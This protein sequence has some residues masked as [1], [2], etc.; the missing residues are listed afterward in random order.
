MS[1]ERAARTIGILAHVDA[2]KTT[3]SERILYLTGAVRALGRVDRGDTVLDSDAIERARGITVFSDQADFVHNGRRYTLIDTPGH[4][5]FAQETERALMALDAA[6][7]MVDAS[8]GVRPHAALLYSLA[9]AR[10]VPVMLFLNKCD[11]ESADPERTLHQARERLNAEPIL[12]PVDPER[13]AELD[14]AFL[15]SYLSGEW[16]EDDLDRALS[17]AFASGACIPALC[18]SALRGGGVGEL[19]N[20]LDKLIPERNID[21]NAPL[22][23]VVYKIRRDSR[24]QRMAFIKLEAG[25]LKP[26]DVFAGGE[27]TEK[28]GEIRRAFGNRY[29]SIGEARA[30]DAVAVTGLSTVSP[31]DR[32]EMSGG[33]R[34]W[35]HAQE[36]TIRAAL[37]AKVEALDGTSP[38]LLNEKLRL[39]EDEDPLLNVR[40]DAATKE[41]L[42][43]VMGPIQLEV[44][45]QMLLE[46]FGIRAH[47]LPSEVVYMETIASPVLGCG[48][49]EPLRHY[50]E[51]ILRLEP[52][53]RGSGITFESRCHVDTLAIQYQ[54]LIRSHVF[55]R[56]HRGK[57]IGAELADVHVVLLNGRAHEKHTEGGDFREATYRAIRQGIMNAKSVLLEPFYRMEIIVPGEYAGRVAA[58]IQTLG[59]ELE[60][61]ERLESDVRIRA[62]GPV[63]R[64]A[65]Y[66]VKLRASTRGTGGATLSFDG[67]DVCRDAESVIRAHP[68]DPNADLEQPAGS[69]FCSHGAGVFVPWNEAEARMHCLKK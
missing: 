22:Q 18:G 28:I 25:T 44:L 9:R 24:G 1:T 3:L 40:F 63:A 34:T 16:N 35:R 54:K 5:D 20:A 15:E 36:G 53:R 43:R 30:G 27:Q 31:G 41:T 12:L 33:T 29:E 62:R 67:Y 42:V 2:G 58:E 14:E 50:A 26:R 69:V 49:Y 7:L 65:D 59:G 55:E 60:P 56:A 47:F 66:G 13:V 48:H 11:L 39:L 10:G 52:G 68:Y 61:P 4:V 17:R 23:G 6:V 19:L 57:E 38:N 8:D 37:S 21:P 46:R 51:V 32:I 64:F 45:E